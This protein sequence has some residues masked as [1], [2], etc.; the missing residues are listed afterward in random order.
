MEPPWRFRLALGLWGFSDPAAWLTTPGAQSHRTSRPGISPSR[1]FARAFGSQVMSRSGYPSTL[2]GRVKVR[3]FPF[4]NHISIRECCSYC[5][6][7]T[8]N[9]SSTASSFYCP[10]YIRRTVSDTHL[11]SCVTTSII[12]PLT[13]GVAAYKA[14]FP[15]IYD[16]H[17]NSRCEPHRKLTELISPLTYPLEC[18]RQNTSTP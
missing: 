6:V 18:P 15:I 3:G 10:N 1:A 16:W 8:I 12:P 7:I 4:L 9:T 5:Y 13:L 14:H 2:V 17:L 11:L